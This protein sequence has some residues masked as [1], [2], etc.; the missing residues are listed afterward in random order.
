MSQP[1][2][3]QTRK[4]E[5]L[6]GVKATFPLIVGAIPFG[7]IFGALA[8]TA[9]LSDSAT[10]GMSLFVFAGSAQFIAAKLI[11]GGSGILLIVFTTLI[12]NLRHMLYAA[13]MSP[14]VQNLPQ[15]WLVPLGFWLTDESFV[16]TIQRYQ[17]EDDSPNKH[18]FF[19]GSAVFMYANWQMCTFIGI[20]AGQQIE[21]PL[22]WGLDFAMIV[23]FI[24]MTVSMLKSKSVVGAVVASGVAA[25]VLRGMPHK[26]G[27]VIAA[28]VGV[29]VGM[30]LYYLLKESGEEKNDPTK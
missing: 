19:F 15:K 26:L 23:T 25:F 24:G 8:S 21:D 13:T 29:G 3:K 7:I 30:G 6:A 22:K 28:L 27:L 20:L 5:F 18:W 12:V 2:P 11:A 1:N 4:A 17:R 10:Q 14:H 9:G 16:T